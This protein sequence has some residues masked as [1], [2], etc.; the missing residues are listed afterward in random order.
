V[1]KWRYN[2]THFL[3]GPFDGSEWSTSRPGCFI[4][5]IGALLTDVWEAVWAPYPV[6]N[7]IVKKNIVPVPGIEA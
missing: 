2:S 4:S 3:P 1:G 6:G 5:R 7:F